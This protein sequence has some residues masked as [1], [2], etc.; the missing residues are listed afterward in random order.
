MLAG[1]LVFLSP[2]I[3]RRLARP[4]QLIGI[5]LI[6]ASILTARAAGWP[7]VGALVP[8]IGTGLMIA[9]GRQDS[10]ITGNPLATWI[11]LRSY[12]IYLWHWPL[13]VLLA[14]YERADDWTIVLAALALSLFAGHLSYHLVERRGWRA[15]IRR[16][17]APATA[18]GPG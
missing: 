4:A 15:L 2:Q 7:G 1:G 10:R 17:T 12:S 6:T 11:G 18:P 16:K 3:P 14:R 5:A 8:V 13:A 9:A